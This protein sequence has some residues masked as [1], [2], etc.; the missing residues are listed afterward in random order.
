LETNQQHRPAKIVH[1]TRQQPQRKKHNSAILSNQELTVFFFGNE[2]VDQLALWSNCTG[3][4]NKPKNRLA[5]LVVE[6]RH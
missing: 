5:M 2:L 3:N 1:V 4:A 6:L